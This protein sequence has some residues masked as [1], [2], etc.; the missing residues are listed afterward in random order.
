MT[1]LLAKTPLA[2]S[3][4]SH[5]TL[6]SHDLQA[7]RRFYEEVLGLEVRQYTPVSI[8]IIGQNYL[9]AA[10]HAANA[11]G[12]MPDCYRN[13]LLLERKADVDAAHAE[14]SAVADDY[15]IQSIGSIVDDADRYY[16]Q[17]RDLDGNLWDIAFDR[18][19]G[20]DRLFAP[21]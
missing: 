18:N 9:Y 8:H 6:E 2:N 19:G 16:F 17:L 3:T 20:F 1:A 11:T 4:L 21:S 13:S 15:G 5:G 10:V 7:T 14:I 12:H